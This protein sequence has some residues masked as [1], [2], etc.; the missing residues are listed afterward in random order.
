MSG[1]P[2]TFLTIPTNGSLYMINIGPGGAGNSLSVIPAQS[3]QRRIDRDNARSVDV[4]EGTVILVTPG[5]RRVT[6]ND[7]EW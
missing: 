5:G 4:E 2:T 1:P 6:G 7:G 3:V